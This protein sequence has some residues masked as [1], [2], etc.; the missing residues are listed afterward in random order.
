MNSKTFRLNDFQQVVIKCALEEY[1]NLLEKEYSKNNEI[2]FVIE[3]TIKE[4]EA[5]IKKLAM[6]EK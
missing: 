3:D 5:I 2:Y 1:A 4:I 6:E